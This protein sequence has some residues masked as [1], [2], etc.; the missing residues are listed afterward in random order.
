MS[1]TLLIKSVKAIMAV[2]H[3]FHEV[4]DV[5]K[6]TCLQNV[7]APL[8]WYTMYIPRMYVLN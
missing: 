2:L 7:C 5:M 4:G 8:N 6:F 3:A 1:H